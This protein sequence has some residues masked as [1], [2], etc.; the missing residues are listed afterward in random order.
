MNFTYYKYCLLSLVG[1]LVTS[2]S[3][4]V[5]NATDINRKVFSNSNNSNV[6]SS[7]SNRNFERVIARE[8]TFKAPDNKSLTNSEQLIKARGYKV[9]VY[10]SAEDLLLQV[11]N[12]EPRAF[13][14]GNVIQVGIFSQQDN[15]EDLVRKLAGKGL[16]AR[17]ITQ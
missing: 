13:I 1:L 9:E 8:Y 4:I 17:I 15:A 14:K 10:G 5:A 2:N 12:I 6:Y 16:W 3:A 11:R 7:R